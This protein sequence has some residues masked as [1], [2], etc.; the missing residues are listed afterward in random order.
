MTMK[1][2]VESLLGRKA[3]DQVTN[4]EG[5]ITSVTF[6]LFGCIQALLKPPIGDD[7]KQV[8]SG[9]FDIGRL[10]L[11]CGTPVMKVPDFVVGPIESLTPKG[12]ANKP[13]T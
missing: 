4:A 6:D 5:V 10:T 8:P 9:W 12:P 7:G 13:I 3:R 1:E 11:I 2:F